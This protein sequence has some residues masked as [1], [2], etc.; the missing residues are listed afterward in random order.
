MD[1]KILSLC[2]RGMTTRDIMATFKETYDADVSAGIISKV[3]EAV[4]GKVT[5]W[6]SRPLDAIYPIIYLD[7]IVVKIRQDKRVINKGSIWHWVLI[8]MATKN[9]WVCGYQRMKG[10]SAG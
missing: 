2:A 7:C 4:I 1:D 5:E 6:Q 3:T 8:W 10:P 9:Y